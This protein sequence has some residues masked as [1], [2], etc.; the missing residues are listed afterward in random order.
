MTQK[1]GGGGKVHPLV[2]SVPGSGSSLCGSVHNW[3]SFR[4]GLFHQCQVIK[5][6]TGINSDVCDFKEGC[7]ENTAN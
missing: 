4:T 7:V 2:L 3:I 6:L 5:F 1:R